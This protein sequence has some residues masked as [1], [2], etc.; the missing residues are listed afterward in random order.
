MAKPIVVTSM[1]QLRRE[2]KRAPWNKKFHAYKSTTLAC[3]GSVKGVN[4]SY[5]PRLKC[6]PGAILYVPQ[7]NTRP[8]NP[9]AAGVNV[10]TRRWCFKFEGRDRFYNGGAVWLL[11]DRILWLVEFT[12]R[13]VACVP[14][15]S[16]GK[17]RLFRCKVLQEVEVKPLPERNA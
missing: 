4:R 8:N 15:E 2:L 1:R 9:C 3:Y 11:R 5:K 17:F 14:D 7:A 6:K 16:D 13:D 10:A 12:A